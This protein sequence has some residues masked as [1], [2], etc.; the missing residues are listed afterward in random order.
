MENYHSPVAFGTISNVPKVSVIVPCFNHAPYLELRLKTIFGQTE[1]DFEV[2]VLDDASTDDSRQ[3][4]AELAL[5]YP[6]RLLANT[7]NS[8]SPFFQWEKGLAST[9]G[10]YVW[11][12]ESDDYSDPNF[13]KALCAI[14]DR[15]PKVGLA[16]CDSVY[17]DENGNAFPTSDLNDA[18]GDDRWR[19]DFIADGRKEC[20]DHLVVRNTIP[21]ASAVLF[22]R[23][24]LESARPLAGSKICGDW[25]TYAKVLLESDL[26][27]HAAPLN[28]YRWHTGCVRYRYLFDATSRIESLQVID[29][30]K[31]RIDIPLARL[32]ASV[33]HY[34]DDELLLIA[35]RQGKIPR[36][37]QKRF[38]SLSR[39][40]THLPE[41]WLRLRSLWVYWR[42]Y[43]RRDRVRWQRI[44][45]AVQA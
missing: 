12:A 24:A 26:A 43:R 29:F 39:R 38:L 23:S 25:L 1:G 18:S 37:M 27:F 20:R 35:W 30:I 7:Q 40:L 15:E 41:T 13:L 6:F 32:R 34:W 11:F 28:Y 36:S 14:L 45:Q 5:R 22:R 9:T 44:L 42:K 33:Y 17:V 21:N 16:Y 2:C 4:L 19:Q 31:N 8:G 3:V 10:E